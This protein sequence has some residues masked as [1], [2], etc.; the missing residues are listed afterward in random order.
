[1]GIMMSHCILSEGH[2]RWFRVASNLMQYFELGTRSGSD[3]W[4]EARQVG[5][6]PEEFLFNGRLYLPLSGVMGT[7]ID[8]FPKS[9]PP[10]GW[11]QRR[12]VGFEGY[13]LFDP[14]TGL[15]LFGYKVLNDICLV[16]TALH[17]RRG[18]TI[19][20]TKGDDFSVHVGPARLGRHGIYIAPEHQ[21]A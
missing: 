4:L 5:P 18:R 15:V 8:N 12:C 21:A 13:E 10:P 11:E 9:P 6:A 2:T 16:T 14:D 17:D 3:Y 1:M 20:E 19:A 7:V